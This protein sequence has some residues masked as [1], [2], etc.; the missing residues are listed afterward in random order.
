MLKKLRL[1]LT[2]LC[3]LL[4]GLVLLCMAAAVIAVSEGQAKQANAT[5]FQSSINT[6]V[7]KLQ[8][9]QSVSITWLAQL[10][11]SER[12]LIH[13]EDNG[14][15]LFFRGAWR[16]QTARSELVDAAKEKAGEL[17]VN[18]AAP[19]ASRLETSSV[20][21]ELRGEQGERYLAAVVQ[22]PTNRSWQSLTL[23]RDMT[24]K[25]AEMQQ[26]RF[27]YLGL[28][29]LSVLALFGVSWWFA[30]RSIKPIEENTRK[31]VE[32]VAAASHELRS[33]LAVI[34]AS[35]AAMRADPEK[36]EHFRG[37][38]EREC[39]RMGR[40][41]SDL[42]LLAGSDAK[43][44]SIQFSPVELDTLLIET[45]ELFRP[46]AWERKQKL[47]LEL[48]EDELPELRGDAQRLQQALSVLID[49]ALHY[50]PEGGMVIV[51]AITG[52]K[53]VRLEVEDNGPGI[54]PEHAAH[55]F[56]RFYR[57]DKSRND[58]SHF[59]LGLSIAQELVRL[60]NGR[61]SVQAA[62]SGGALFIVE[63]PAVLRRNG[64]DS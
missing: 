33:P 62:S 21:F 8:S 35:A 39:T 55:I 51:R 64:K 18:A 25:D 11:S 30:G 17:G 52:Q 24:D 49:N 61:I 13:I 7:F 16:P 19:P 28:A 26:Q 37:N 48:P 32:F 43:T 27:L 15:P 29:L 38:I 40:L 5:A 60:H 58:K 3:S 2:L 22:I 50:T 46:L 14:T 1:R 23:M 45:V 20:Q 53:S 4:T 59:G 63:L 34:Q 42:L 31:Q 56:D 41:V 9:D 36:G 47:T 12:L 10:E 44:W 6:I 57:V 54:P